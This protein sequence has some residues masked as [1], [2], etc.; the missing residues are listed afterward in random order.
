M[1]QANLLPLLSPMSHGKLKR[2]KTTLTLTTFDL[3]CPLMP[4]KDA[5]NR[6][7]AETD[8]VA[9]VFGGKKGLKDVGKVLFRNAATRISYTDLDV[10]F[11]GIIMPG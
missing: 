5:I 4:F 1:C 6:G 11:R 7:K 2:K 10:P 3:D 8:P 9:F